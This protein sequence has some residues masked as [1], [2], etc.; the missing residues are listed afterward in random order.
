MFKPVIGNLELNIFFAPNHGG[1]H[2]RS[3]LQLYL[4]GKVTNHF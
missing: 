3:V 2:L 4:L 1:Q